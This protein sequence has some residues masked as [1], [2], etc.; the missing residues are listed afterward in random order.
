ML[1]RGPWVVSASSGLDGLVPELVFATYW[2]HLPNLRALAT[3]GLAAPLYSCHPPITVP[4]W[5]VMMNGHDPGSLGTYGF[6]DRADRSYDRRQ[7]AS[8]LTYAQAPVWTQLSAAGRRCKL[9]TVPQTYPPLPL[10]GAMVAGHPTPPAAPLATYPPELAAQVSALAEHWDAALHGARRLAPEQLLAAVEA[11]T[12]ALF[13]QAHAWCSA[14]DWDFF[15]MVDMGP[16]RLQHGLWHLAFPEPGAA[17]TAL[18]AAL[19]AYYV[20]PRTAGSDAWPPSVAQPT[21]S[22]WSPTT[23]PRPCAAPWPSTSG[24]WTRAICACTRRLSPGAAFTPAQVDWRRTRAWADG[25]YVGRIHLNVAKREPAGIVA[26][27]NAPALLAELTAKLT[28]LPL[29]PGCSGA[30]HRLLRPT[31]TYAHCRGVP[32]ESVALC[33]RPA[34]A[35]HRLPGPSQPLRARQRPGSRPRQPRAVRLPAPGDA[36]TIDP[37]R[38]GEHLRRRANVAA[39][40]G[41]VPADQPA[42]PIPGRRTFLSGA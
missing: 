4:A 29:P 19:Q 42:R 13:R 7:L 39:A 31:A 18:Q 17:P 8:S 5:A 32:P 11:H 12:E 26:A 27:Q 41:P 14:P 1:W 9:L 35:L 6:Q 28:A 36:A 30:P 21:A 3:R 34:A 24:S 37:P 25:G 33:R 40:V 2:A 22:W 23:A 10:H 20:R 38:G 16:D 15:M